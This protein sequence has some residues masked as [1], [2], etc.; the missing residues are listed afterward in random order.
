MIRPDASHQENYV[1]FSEKYFRSLESCDRLDDHG[2]AKSALNQINVNGELGQYGLGNRQV[3]LS[4]DL[5]G[6]K[7]VFDDFDTVRII[8]CVD[9]QSLNLTKDHQHEVGGA[10]SHSEHHTIR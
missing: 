7:F 8:D 10:S 6:K 2:E 9:T 1:D 5:L 4:Q 3:V